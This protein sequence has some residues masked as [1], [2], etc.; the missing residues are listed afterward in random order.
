MLGHCLCGKVEFEVAADH[1]KLYQCHCSLCRR[2]GGSS[3]NTA[4]IVPNARF[5]W[6]RGSAGIATWQ[7]ESGFRSDFCS[8]C[9]SPVPNPLRGLPYFWVPAG[10]LENDAQLEIV[11]HLCVGSKP[12]WDSTSLRGPCF[13]HL[14]NLPEFIALLG[15][16]G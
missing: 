10:L 13:E 4:G 11:A 14:P 16:D 2:Q 7:K 9:G 8:R 6:L 3:S 12:V 1:L 5:R 15:V